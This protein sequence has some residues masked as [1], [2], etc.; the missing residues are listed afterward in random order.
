M[1][2]EEHGGEEPVG[3]KRKRPNRSSAD[4]KSN[5]ASEMWSDKTGS[6]I[7]HHH[8][9]F[10]LHLSTKKTTCIFVGVNA[11]MIHNVMPKRSSS[12]KRQKKRKQVGGASKLTSSQEASM[13]KRARERY[14]IHE[15]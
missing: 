7:A 8:E 10:C 12:G 9:P 13:V 2:N 6:W 5:S 3:V 15:T 1:E 11:D 14:M 4:D